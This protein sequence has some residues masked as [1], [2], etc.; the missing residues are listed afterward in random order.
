ML[1]G[2]VC[3]PRQ[4]GGSPGSWDGR[5]ELA[6]LAAGAGAGQDR[7]G[8]AVAW[9]GSQG[10]GKT[11]TV[12]RVRPFRTR[13]RAG[14]VRDHVHVLREGPPPIFLSSICSTSTS[15]SKSGDDPRRIREKVTGKLPTLDEA[16]R[17]TLPAGFTSGGSGMI[18]WYAS[19]SMH[20]TPQHTLDAVKRLAAAREPGATAHPGV[21]EPAL[22]RFRDPGPPRPP[23]GEP[24]NLPAAPARQLLPRVTSIAGGARPTIQLRLDPLLP[25]NAMELLPR[26]P[27]GGRQPWSAQAALIVDGGQPFFPGGDRPDFDRDP[28]FA[29]VSGGPI[30]PTSPGTIARCRRR[31]GSV[32]SADRPV[33]V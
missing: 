7:Q 4:R 20:P 15:R 26:P 33:P 2:S 8:Q 28:R 29:R 16:L 10:A 14:C 21:R 6:G 19:R 24:P 18:A 31:P 30:A 13:T 3:K 23:G 5:P 22:D 9:S 12:L 17:P 1:P 27:G 11:P 25:E 32:G